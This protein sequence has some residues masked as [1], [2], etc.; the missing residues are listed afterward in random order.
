[1]SPASEPKRSEAGDSRLSAFVDEFVKYLSMERGLAE[2]S[3]LAYGSDL[4]GYLAWTGKRDPLAA[5]ARVIEDYL[6]HLRE[7]KGLKAV[8]VFRKMEALRAF[9]RFQAV[10]DRIKEDP[11]RDFRSPHLPDRLPKYLT[12]D[13]MSRLLRVR[14][15][16]D[17]AALRARTEL[18]LLYAT[19]MRASE[20]LG[21]KPEDVNLMEGVAR[22]LGKGS[23]ERLIPLHTKA[24]EALSK[25]LAERARR[26][27]GRG[28]S[29]QVF[30][31]RSGKRLSR[32]QLWRDLRALGK[33]AKLSRELHP[34]LLR[35]TFASHLLQGGADARSVQEML[36]HASLQT[37][38]IYTHLDASGLKER[39]K[40]H[41]PRG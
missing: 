1:M 22:V 17:F 33:K 20:L 5:D 39:H 13:E 19:G 15:G 25:Y 37:T 40:R 41:H 31:G 3:C 14:G 7:E 11:T 2:N 26:F 34:H 10:E 24:R 4:A 21:L 32:V 35:H 8:S 23:K 6:W 9:Y 38:Q 16:D 36:G 12:L 30:V 28:P 18:E 27:E 29:P